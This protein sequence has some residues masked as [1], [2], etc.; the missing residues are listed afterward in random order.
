MDK[1][2]RKTDG[3][4]LAAIVFAAVFV[5]SLVPV[6][7][8]SFYSHPLTDD[9]NFSLGVHRAFENGG[10]VAQ[11]LSAAFETV[12]DNYRNWQG[13]F[14][15]IFVFALQPGAFGDGWYPLTAFIMLGLL[16]LSTWTLLKTLLT[17]L[18]GARPA[19]TVIVSAAMLFL[20][21]QFVPDKQQAYYWFNGSSY[22]TVFYALLL[23]FVS[24]LIRFVSEGNRQAARFVFLLAAAVLLG[25]G[26]YSTGILA[27]EIAVLLAGALIIKK[28]PERFR[29]LAVALACTAAFAVSVFAPGNAVRALENT[30]TPPVTAVLRSFKEGAALGLGYMRF[31][32][33]LYVLLIFA[34]MLR[35][36]KEP[37][38]GFPVPGA[39]IALSF[40]LFCSMLT[41]PIY[42]MGYTG[43]GRQQDIY[44]YAWLMLV[45][46]WV[47]Y[48]CGWLNAK[49]P[50]WAE[51]LF[52]RLR[53]VPKKQA[54]CIAAAFLLLCAGHVLAN[55]RETGHMTSVNTGLALIRGTAADYDRRYREILKTMASDEQDVAVRE[56]EPY[57]VFF[58]K[59]YLED[60]P[61]AWANAQLAEYFGKRSVSLK[62]D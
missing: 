13:T 11:V 44:Y 28:H 7:G 21:V 53:A 39:V 8:V 5:L 18:G 38:Y 36:A 31:A 12:K 62:K 25:G 32:E 40:A 19:Y 14:A 1:N 43:E 55:I 60:D 3:L 59:M 57:P 29:V 52:C 22:Y 20:S 23:F 47:W 26:N 6:L 46:F 56:L 2:G 15:A 30:V 24:A 49:K 34:V 61:S 10:G 42:A 51:K 35:A 48:V 54:F 4:R 50:G 41:P 16:I 33:L 45:T 17:R 27:C 9:Y 58:G 37:K